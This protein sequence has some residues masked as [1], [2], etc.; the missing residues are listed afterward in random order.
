MVFFSMSEVPKK[1]Q[2][3]STDLGVKRFP[4]FAH[5]HFFTCCNRE[6]EAILLWWYRA[7]EVV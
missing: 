2:S 1:V 5:H 3:E 6:R 4:G 7:V